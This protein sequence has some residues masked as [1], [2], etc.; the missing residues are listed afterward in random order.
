MIWVTVHLIHAALNTPHLVFDV[1]FSNVLTITHPLRMVTFTNSDNINC[2]R[3]GCR[4][5]VNSNWWKEL[6]IELLSMWKYSHKAGQHFSNFHWPTSVTLETNA[7]SRDSESAVA[8]STPYTLQ[9]FIK[10]SFCRFL[11]YEVQNA[12]FSSYLDKVQETQRPRAAWAGHMMDTTKV[13]VRQIRHI[14]FPS[15][16]NF[17]YTAV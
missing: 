12:Q 14:V 4:G 15:N 5:S 1:T 6:H 9:L 7:T 13:V 16:F 2:F 10:E 8:L 3:I 11:Q 17:F